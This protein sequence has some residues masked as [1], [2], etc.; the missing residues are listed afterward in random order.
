VRASDATGTWSAWVA[1]ASAAVTR[2]QESSR[3][4]R[5]TGRWASAASAGASGASVRFSTSAGS[6]ATLGF[7]GRGVTWVA[8]RGPSRGSARIYVDGAY[9]TTVSLYSATTTPRVLA[10]SASWSAAGAHS[11]TIRVVGTK[12][13]PRV[14]LDAI[15]I[16]R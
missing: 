4:I 13:H 12:G 10:F 9:R 16:L 1:G 14:D 7:T 8:P 3:S 5:W 15:A 11:I 6:T 2:L